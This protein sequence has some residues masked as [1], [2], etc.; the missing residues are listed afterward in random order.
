M[1]RHLACGLFLLTAVFC[2]AGCGAAN[3]AV[4]SPGA[5][6]PAALSYKLY[7]VNFGPYVTGNPNVDMVTY[8]EAGKLLNLLKPRTEWVRTYTCGNVKDRDTS[9]AA[10]AKARGFQVAA[11]CW[12]SNDTAANRREINA[13]KIAIN[14]K[15]VDLAV[16]G[17]ET[18]YRPNGLT[19]AAL[20]AY[21]REVKQLGVPTTTGDTWNELVS[22]PNVVNECSVVFA[23]IFPYWEK[24]RCQDA[25]RALHGHYLALKQAFPGKEIL[26]SEAGW[27]SAGGDWGPAH[28]SNYLAAYYFLNF[29]SWARAENVKYFYFEAFDEPWKSAEGEV[30]GALGDLRHQAE[31][32]GL[33]VQGLQRRDYA[34]QLVDAPRRC[35]D[36]VHRGSRLR[37]LQQPPGQGHRHSAHRL[38]GG[39]LHLHGRRLVDQAV[40]DGPAHGYR[41]RR[42]LGVQYHHRRPYL[43]RR[44]GHPDPRLP[45][46]FD[47]HDTSGAVGGPAAQSTHGRRT[48]DGLGDALAGSLRA[49]GGRASIS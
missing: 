8:A 18:L 47:L 2:L 11:G 26:I 30:G 3:H 31:P 15:Q 23:N 20:I 14:R 17:S 44:A 46:P 34:Q 12:L 16:V 13:L 35:R 6:A 19:E 39:R 32:E 36:Q 48:G 9:L 7:G 37:H 10:M 49:C 41:R 25:M 22:H 33:D 5:P 40:L 4:D 27:P 28:P 42:L 1:G 21:L 43:Q 45:G 29:V 38:Q 24:V